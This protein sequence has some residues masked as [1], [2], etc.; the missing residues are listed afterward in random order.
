MRS[1]LVFEAS[2]YVSN[3]VLVGTPTPVDISTDTRMVFRTR[4][5]S[6]TEEVPV[7]QR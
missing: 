2:T 3:R 7:L 4:E 1:E 6:S 5:P